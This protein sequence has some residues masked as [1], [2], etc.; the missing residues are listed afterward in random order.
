[1]VNRT[2]T[3]TGVTI[4]LPTTLSGLLNRIPAAGSEVV[5]PAR[6]AKSQ[7][8]QCQPSNS[9]DK[10]PLPLV[11]QRHVWFNL[12]C[13]VMSTRFQTLCPTTIIIGPINESKKVGRQC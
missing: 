4:P 1:M 2:L 3:Q 10:R 13:E 6:S 8:W 11:L 12:L 5:V 7:A 9:L